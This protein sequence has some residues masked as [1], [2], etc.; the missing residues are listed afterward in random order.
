MSAIGFMIPLNKAD[1]TS[2]A[3][4]V[5]GPRNICATDPSSWWTNENIQFTG[6][7]DATTAR[8]GDTVVIQVGVQ[9]LTNE[10]LAAFS[11]IQNVQAWVCYPN[12]VAGGASA[13]L[14]VPSMQN[15]PASYSDTTDSAFEVEGG[16]VYEDPS[17]SFHWIPLSSW[18]PTEDDFLGQSSHE[19]HCCVIANAAGFANYSN[20]PPNPTPDPIP[21]GAVI[22][23]DS[24]LS[25]QINIC[26]NPWQ[27]Q[28]NVA[29]VAAGAI[30]G[31]RANPI[32]H[33]LS[34][35]P[36]LETSSKT[37]IAVTAIDQ[38]GQIDPVIFK[39]LSSGPHARLPLKPA[40]SPPKSL[41]LVRHPHE[42]GGWLAEIIR[43]AEEIVEELLGLDQHKFGGGH[44]LNLSLPPRG[45]Q[46]LRLE[47]E[48]DPTDPP[49]AVHAIDITQ[50][51]ANGARGGIRVGLVVIP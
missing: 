28:R 25:S 46:P 1:Y 16:G 42:R 2:Y 37:T 45:L 26:T 13:S 31:I 24:E 49:G 9:G 8:V 3:S 23:P 14:V 36:E 10:G 17:F 51:D 35:A 41:R 50:T 21:E 44:K 39:V 38:K 47:V 18:T 48:L 29:I 34:G 4:N 30:G 40:S 15:N 5:G 32:F 27:G 12:T 33:F 22:T 7:V 20:M 43:E 6:T 11:V 19:G